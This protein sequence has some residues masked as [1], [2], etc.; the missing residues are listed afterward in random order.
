MDLEGK[1]E[2]WERKEMS[3]KEMLK[4]HFAVEPVS[5]GTWVFEPKG[6]Q[7]SRWKADQGHFPRE[8]HG[9]APAMAMDCHGWH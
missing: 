7:R 5:L 3:W 2:G 8:R 6:K 4:V 1:K 9:G